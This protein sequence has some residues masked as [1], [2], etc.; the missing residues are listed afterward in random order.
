[1]DEIIEKRKEHLLNFLKTKQ[2]WIFLF[3]LLIVLYIGANIRIQNINLLKDQTTNDYIPA[4]LDAMLFDSYAK[5]IV[6]EGSLPDIDY[7]RN[8]PFGVDLRYI[9]SGTAYFSAYLYKILKVFNP[10]ITVSLTHSVL[11]PV[12]ATILGSIFFF[13]LIRLIFG[14]LTA[15]LATAFLNVM[16]AYLTRTVSG[17]SDKEPLGMLLIYAVLYFYLK[18]FK[19]EKTFLVVIFA[20]ISGFLT[21][22]LSLSW[23][24]VI[25]IFTIIPF[26]YLLILLFKDYNK[27]DLIAYSA[28]LFLIFIFVG[29]LTTKYGGLKA[30]FTS[31]VFLIPLGMLFYSLIILLI[32]KNEKYE[33]LI[34]AKIPVS[35]AALIITIV[36]GAVFMISILGFNK[37][38]GEIIGF[39]SKL[40]TEMTHRWAIT[41]AENKQ[42]SF[43]DWKGSY[44]LSYIT[45]FMLGAL[46]LFYNTFKNIKPLRYKYPI[47]F[48]VFLLTFTLSNYSESSILNGNTPFSKLFYFGGVILFVIVSIYFYLSLYRKDKEA[49]KEFNQ[50]KPEYFLVIIWFL[51]MIVAAR[52]SVRFLFTLVPPITIMGSYFISEIHNYIK[53]FKYIP[54]N[55]LKLIISFIFLILILFIPVNGS[56]LFFTKNAYGMAKG[57]GPIYNVQ[58]QQAGKWIREN[59]TKDAVFAH[60]WDYGYMVQDG[61]DRATITDGG[62]VIIYWN[63][64]LGRHVLLGQ[65]ETEALEFLYAHNATHLLIVNEEIG[66]FPAYSSIGSDENYDRYSILSTFGLDPSQSKE[67]RDGNLLVYRGQSVIDQDFVIDDKLIPEQQAAIVGFVIEVKNISVNETKTASFNQPKAIVYYQGKQIEVPVNCIF[68]QNRI[69]RY[70]KTKNSFDGCIRFTP[71][72]Q[73]ASDGLNVNELGAFIYLSPKVSRTLFAQ[74]Y[75]LNN[76]KEWSNFKKVYDPSVTPNNYD[77]WSPLGV[78]NGNLIGPIKIWEISYPKD[79]KFKP[80]Y[81]ET[82]YTNPGLEKSR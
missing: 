55:N 78:Y 21:G 22:L 23:G 26:T 66:K 48:A 5:I 50:I 47:I 12:I 59:T 27:K 28:W 74:L 73:Q 38:S 15:L 39:I 60:W 24:G 67:T 17:F 3:L 58:W 52:T 34:S 37:F 16:P 71:V 76:E 82:R 45:I 46:L 57:V 4:D 6:K 68:L 30:F 1:M 18:S 43:Q 63:H 51:A 54:N 81:L 77:V 11:Y 62:N 2:T 72:Y 69:E 49:F 20:V 56:F 29:F 10:E 79:I 19:A 64:L 61:A 41:V 65:N 44:T 42:P 9:D 13:L 32:K 80:E 36:L 31:Y 8:Y 70:P 35:I 33:K 25:F 7:K 75:L 40:S 53:N 14:N